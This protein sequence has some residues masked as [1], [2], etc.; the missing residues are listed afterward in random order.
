MRGD[1]MDLAQMTALDA[2]QSIRDGECT[3]MDMVEACLTR[4]Q[5]YDAEIQAWAHLDADMAKAQAEALDA[6]KR[7]GG[8]LGPLHGVPVGVKDIFDTKD[9]PTEYGTPIHA[10][11]YAWEDAWAVTKL[12]EAGAII[13]GK[14]VTTE[15]AVMHPGKTLNPHNPAHTP[16]GSSSGSA[17]AVASYMVPLATGTQTN[18]SVIRPASY[19]GV[20]GYKPSFGMIGR[21]GVRR[22]AESLDHVGT[23]GRTIEDAVLMAE[24]MAG[25]DARDPA[26]RLRPHP[27]L[28]AA[29]QSEPVMAPKLAFAK[30][31]VWDQ[32][33]SDCQEAFGELVEHL[34]ED[35]AEINLKGV[36]EQAWDWLQIIMEVELAHNLGADFDSKGEAFSAELAQTVEAGRRHSGAAY[37]KAKSEAASLDFYLTEIFDNYDAILCPATTGVAPKGLNTTG[38]PVFC[39]LWSLTGCPALSL[40]LMQDDQGMP[41]GVQL[42]GAKNDDARL[43]RTASWLNKRLIDDVG[44]G[45]E[46]E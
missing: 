8:P 28:V 20:V 7:T 36:F 12:R 18:G 13:L 22:C 2:A 39:S 6:Y 30:T 46:Q 10:G 34:G 35:V 42:V 32:A 23:F 3:A 24:V 15:Y 14:T 11:H 41:L 33:D 1:T 16:G 9:Y 31:P 27:H 4:I 5:H 17:A 37:L 40:P 19:C 25:Y 43:V 44:P 29:S 26:T 45:D 21:T 38:S